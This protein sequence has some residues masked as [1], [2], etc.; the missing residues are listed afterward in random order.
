MTF[1]EKNMVKEL[2]KTISS[3][4]PLVLCFMSKLLQK[5]VQKLLKGNKLITIIKIILYAFDKTPV[6]VKRG[7]LGY[8]EN[9]KNIPFQ[10]KYDNITKT[11]TF[12]LNKKSYYFNLCTANEYIRVLANETNWMILKKNLNTALKNIK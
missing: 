6:E 7:V 1:V 3:K 9:E 11:L 10:Y 8:V 4:K 5:E 12:S 2:K